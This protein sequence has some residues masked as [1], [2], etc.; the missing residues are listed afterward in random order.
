M[1]LLNFFKKKNPTNFFEFPRNEVGF[2]QVINWVNQCTG[3]IIDIDSDNKISMLSL[4][5]EKKFIYVYTDLAQRIPSYKQNERF[6]TLDYNGL[7]QLFENNLS[8]DFIWL[9]PNSDSVQIN[10]SN[11][12][13]TYVIKENTAV[14]IG[15]PAN[16]PV[17][18]ISFL[19]DVA[20]KNQKIRKIYFALMHNNGNFSFV[21]T[22]DSDCSED[23]IKSMDSM[24]TKIC[25]DNNVPY[26]VDFLY[27]DLIANEQY[28]I[29]PDKN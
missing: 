16:L 24:V 3:L 27:G 6:I 17:E 4:K 21:V 7:V 22:I 19:I 18:L 28:Q 20:H 12:T 25:L 5:E 1:S 29:Y 14:Q 9:N 15:Q 10:R 23:I 26:P 2:N 13:S 11:F 8:L